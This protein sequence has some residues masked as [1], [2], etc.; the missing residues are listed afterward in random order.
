MAAEEVEELKG[1]TQRKSRSTRRSLA[2]SDVQ[3]AK[4]TPIVESAE[5]L[6]AE[7]EPCQG[8]VEEQEQQPPSSVKKDPRRSRRS[9]KPSAPSEEEPMEVE[10]GLCLLI[11][12]YLFIYL[13]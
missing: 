5:E 2:V 6:G 1:K 12:F 4:D 10:E 3:T 8:V 7:A 9:I 11:S 13:F